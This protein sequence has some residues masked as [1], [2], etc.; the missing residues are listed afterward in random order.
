MQQQEIQHTE[1]LL[2]HTQNT[3]IQHTENPLHHK[4]NNL[5]RTFHAITGLRAN[6]NTDELV[7]RLKCMAK[8]YNSILARF[9]Y[10]EIEKTNKQKLKTK[11]VQTMATY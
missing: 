7:A 8:L 5:V 4:Q 6:D 3:M 11:R 2:V 9:L 10:R 1:N